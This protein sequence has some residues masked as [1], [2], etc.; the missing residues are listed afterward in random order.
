LTAIFEVLTA[1]KMTEGRAAALK[2]ETV[3]F[4]ETL[5]FTNES[6]QRKNPKEQ[7][8]FLTGQLHPFATL[9]IDDLQE[10]RLYSAVIGGSFTIKKRLS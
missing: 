8:N 2:M 1:V 10:L 4:S 6:T 3:C 7:C 5:V 9:Y